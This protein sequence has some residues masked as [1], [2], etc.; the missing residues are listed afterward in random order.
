MGIAANRMRTEGQASKATIGAFSLTE[1]AHCLVTSA[2]LPIP[3]LTKCGLA[4][5]S[6]RLMRLLAMPE[7]PQ[8][9][10]QVP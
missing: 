1:L 2:T 7:M 4:G 6:K 9:S 5:T 8:W 10:S 3:L